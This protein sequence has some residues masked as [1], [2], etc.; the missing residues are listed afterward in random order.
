MRPKFESEGNLSEWSFSIIQIT[1]PELS[2]DSDEELT[3]N[4]FEFNLKTLPSQVVNDEALPLVIFD[5]LSE[6]RLRSHAAEEKRLRNMVD[7]LVGQPLLDATVEANAVDNAGSD[8][9][10]CLVCPKVRQPGDRR[11]RADAICKQ[12]VPSQLN[13]DQISQLGKVGLC[14]GILLVCFL[15]DLP[16]GLSIEEIL[17]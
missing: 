11:N 13:A 10:L 8:E 9:V 14:V 17:N 4:Q 6:R 7:G 3:P 15:S 5:G 2:S 16:P 12:G 1:P